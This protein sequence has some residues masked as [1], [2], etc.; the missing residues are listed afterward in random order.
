MILF[1]NI[2]NQCIQSL[3]NVVRRPVAYSVSYVLRNSAGPRSGPGSGSVVRDQEQILLSTWAPIAPNIPRLLSTLCPLLSNL[4][5]RQSLVVSIVPLAN[6]LCNLHAGLCPNRLLGLG[7]PLLR[8][9]EPLPASNIEKLECSLGARARGDVSIPA[10][11]PSVPFHPWLSLIG[12]IERVGILE[13][14]HE[15]AS[16]AQLVGRSRQAPSLWT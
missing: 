7:L 3:N 11:A 12:S 6:R 9:R 5:T 1:P 14:T 4:L 13:R 10:P 8:P 16:W 2:R 15:P